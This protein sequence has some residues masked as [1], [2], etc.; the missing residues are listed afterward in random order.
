MNLL[1]QFIDFFLHIDKNLAIIIQN[2]GILS[3][4]I[5]FLII[6]VETGLVIFPFLPGDSMLFAAGALAANGSFNFLLLWILMG[7]AAV[8]GDTVNYWIGYFI[9]EKAFEP[10]HEISI[11]RFKIKLSKIFKPKYLKK[12]QDFYDKYGGKA[13]ILARFVP[14]VRTFAPFIAGISKMSYKKFISFNFIGGWLWVSL[15]LTAGYLFDNIPL[16]RNNFEIVALGI[17]GVSLL[18]VLFEFLKAKLVATK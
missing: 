1:K 11:G 6:F 5:L 2:Y 9:G 8:L 17:V 12:S 3:Y 14:I 10:H 13:I 16:V 18:P 7:I 4:G 15:F